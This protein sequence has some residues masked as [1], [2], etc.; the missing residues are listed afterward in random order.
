MQN[1]IDLIHVENH[2]LF[3]GHMAAQYQDC[4]VY[5]WMHLVLMGRDDPEGSSS[6]LLPVFGSNTEKQQEKN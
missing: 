5:E 2:A 6:V 3:G 1:Q 4:F